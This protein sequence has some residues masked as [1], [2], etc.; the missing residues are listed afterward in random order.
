MLNGPLHL[1]KT[2]SLLSRWVGSRCWLRRNV[3]IHWSNDW[4]SRQCFPECC[5]CLLIG[6]ECSGLTSRAPTSD[7]SIEGGFGPTLL[8]PSF[9]LHDGT[10]LSSPYLLD[11]FF[12]QVSQAQEVRG[13]G[14]TYVGS[15]SV[16]GISAYRLHSLSE[17]FPV[18]WE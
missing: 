10:T 14:R 5:H 8:H 16:V 6:R 2:P 11:H 15:K 7:E 9:V 3:R 1:V 12:G 18:G 13:C 4:M 17:V